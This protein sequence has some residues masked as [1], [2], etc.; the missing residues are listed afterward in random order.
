MSRYVIDASAWI[1]Y[2]RGSQLGEQVKGYIE[3]KESEA[4]TPLLTIAE[5]VSV[6][7]REGKDH[8]IAYR[9]MLSL[10]KFLAMDP[11]LCVEAGLFHATMRAT[12]KDFG[13]ADAFVFAAAKKIKAKIITK[14]RHFKGFKEAILI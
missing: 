2:L 6:V 13:L 9:H 3:S 8:E 11:E 1:E 12:I 4:F 5:V 14:D 7:R 10:S